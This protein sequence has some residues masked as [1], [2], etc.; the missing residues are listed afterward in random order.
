MSFFMSTLMSGVVTIINTGV[1]EG[2]LSRWLHAGLVAWAVAFPLISLI[3][4][5][6]HRIARSL[7][8]TE[9]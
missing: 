8:E 3:A 2:F 6:A 1:T 4:P 7:V 5:V 9:V